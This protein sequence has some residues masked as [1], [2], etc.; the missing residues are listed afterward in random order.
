MAARG[1]QPLGGQLPLQVVPPEHVPDLVDQARP[2]LAGLL[3]QRGQPA[4][5]LVGAAGDIDVPQAPDGLALQQ[6]ITMD[7]QQLAQRGGVPPIRLAFLAVFELDQNHLVAAVVSQHAN[8]PIVE[9]A[10]L[11]HGHEG[12]AVVQ[13]FAGELLEEGVDLRGLGGH[14]PGLHD[15]AV[16]VAERDGDLPCM[17]IDY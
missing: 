4:V 10:D 3:A 8:E 16:V 15:I 17:L 6:A 12:L 11:E 9:A 5:L 2:C 1:G 7:P 13:A 14:L